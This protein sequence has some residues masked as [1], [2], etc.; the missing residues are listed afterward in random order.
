MTSSVKAAGRGRRTAI[1]AGGLA[2]L[3]GALDT[4]VVV[5]IMTDIMATVGIPINKIQQV[6]PIIT[7]YLLGYIA[8]MP[9][10][11]RLSDR[12]GRK[13]I[14]QLSL[15]VF[16]AGSVVT[17]MSTDLTM[18]VVGRLIQGIASGALPKRRCMPP[19][20]ALRLFGKR[21]LAIL[22]SL[23]FMI[24]TYS[25][26]YSLSIWPHALTTFLTTSAL[27]LVIRAEDRT[28]IRRALHLLATGVLAGIAITTRLDAA[29][30]VP[31]FL[32]VPAFFG[33]TR[34]P[35]RSLQS[36]ALAALGLIPALAFLSLTN[37]A[38]FQTW[39]PFS[40]GPWNAAGGNAGGMTAYAPLAAV[41]VVGLLAAHLVVPR[42]ASLSRSALHASTG[43]GHGCA[44]HEHQAAKQTPDQP[45]S[46]DSAHNHQG[47]EHTAHSAHLAR[48]DSTVCERRTHL[49]HIRT[50]LLEEYRNRALVRAGADVPNPP[51]AFGAV[52]A[53]QAPHQE[54]T[55]TASSRDGPGFGAPGSRSPRRPRLTM[56]G[57]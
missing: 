30:A 24:G 47:D 52:G 25:W 18:L 17:A 38:K 3:L 23:I 39:Q 28:G 48:R 45:T 11:G 44:R 12:F 14:L 56:G 8:A 54:G 7:C 32:V 22:A 31:G 34:S 33:K 35:S 36:S 1:S 16:A 2:V 41:A 15:A 5:T 43:R 27:A 51:G 10:L 19:R 40:Y 37:H 42:M 21:S 55:L 6:T 13:L 29:F 26:E 9:L 20:P 49:L 4:Y 53:R 50:A 46:P 57:T